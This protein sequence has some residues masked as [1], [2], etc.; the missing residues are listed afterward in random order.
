MKCKVGV[1]VCHCGTN[2]AGKIDVEE[3]SSFAR[4]LPHVAL[5]RHYGFMCSE[6][7]QELIRKDIKEH[8]LNRVVVAACS[9]RMHEHT[10]RKAC[11]EA[12]INPYFL[13][14]ANIRE[15]CSW[16]VEDPSEA[17][18]K[19][20]DLLRAAVARVVLHQPLPTKVVDVHPDVLVVGGGIAGIQAAL[21]IADGGHLVHLV[22]REQSIGGRMAQLDK[23]F[24]TLDCSSCILTPKMVSAGTHP[25]IRLHAYSEIEEIS[26]YVGNFHVKILHKPSYVNWELCTGCGVCQEKCPRR[27]PSWFDGGLG[28]RKAIYTLFPQAVP[29]KPVIDRQNCIYFQKGRCRACEKFCEVG[30]IDFEQSPRIEEVQVGSIIV[31]TGY[32]VFDPTTIES[33]GYGRLPNV[34]TS[35]EFERMVSAAGPTGGKILLQDGREPAD[36]AIIH[37]VGSRDKN[38]HEYCSR[39]CCMASL[40]YAHLIREKTSANVFCFYIDMRCF[41]KGYEEFYERLQREGVTFIR[42]KPAQITD[43]AMVPEERGR[44][45]VMAEDTLS[46]TPLRVPVDMVILAVAMEP[47]SDSQDV[48]RSLLLSQG[49]DG[50][51]LEQHPKLAPV[52]TTVSGIFLAGTCQGPKDIPDTVAHASAAASKAL[53]MASRG[54]VEVESMVSEIDP[55]LCSGCQIC[56]SLCPSGAI[57]Y[58]ARSGI[59]QVNEALCKGCGACSAACPSGAA[60]LRHF[61]SQQVMT[62]IEALVGE[63]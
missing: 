55:E 16:A 54:R 24:P 27:V 48:A 34:I 3:L 46:E 11:E 6:P 2:I 29:N 21:D 1:Y 60:S 37:C 5:S 28:R 62:E 14:M 23:T 13:Q 41:G 20:R 26:G 12:G 42:G 7:G 35:M 51:F 43:Q 52:S 19:A 36:V 31:A 57:D 39:V 47:R 38:F 18:S 22:E 15:Q 17:L 49:R 56:I 50:F 10:F 8:G 58:L 63:P 33:Y 30:A 25:L 45:M 32:D 9:P 59:S 44:L 61:T 40:K 4:Q 53:S